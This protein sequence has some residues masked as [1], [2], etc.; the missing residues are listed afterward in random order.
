MSNLGT[1]LIILTALGNL[2][3][4][5]LVYYK[6]PKKLN[7]RLFILLIISV[8]IW[9]LSSHFSNHVD[10]NYVSALLLKIDF[11]AGAFA[12]LFF[13]LFTYC[14]PSRLSNISNIVFVILIGLASISSIISIFTNLLVNDTLLLQNGIAYKQGVLDIPF[15]IY[16]F[17]QLCFGMYLLI[18]K[19][20]KLQGYDKLQTE[21]IFIGAVIPIIL[22]SFFNLLIGKISNLNFAQ[23]TMVIDIIPSIGRFSVAIFTIVTAYVMLKHGLFGVRLVISR[24][25]YWI[26]LVIIQFLSIYLY[27]NYITDKTLLI[28]F[29]IFITVISLFYSKHIWPKVQ[30]YITQ[31]FWEEEEIINN[32]NYKLTQTTSF[33]QACIEL[34]DLIKI[35]FKSSKQMILIYKQDFNQDIRIEKEGFSDSDIKIITQENTLNYFVNNSKNIILINSNSTVC[36]NIDL[37]YVFKINSPYVSGYYFL[38]EKENKQLFINRELDLINQLLFVFSIAVN[39]S[40]IN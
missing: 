35:T 2:I 6:D 17:I 29:S 39:K 3:L 27:V 40:I 18:L 31:V 37:A 4:G 28:I 14:F 26:S 20:T 36:N 1:I 5:G 34:F 8:N 38:G 21:Y 16:I 15:A 7:N 30:R 9:I 10:S 13:V 33:S 32:F 25:I 12:T 19:L 22:I 11:A 23:S 24:V